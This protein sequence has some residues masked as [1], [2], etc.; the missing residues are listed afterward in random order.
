MSNGSEPTYLHYKL[1]LRSPAIIAAFS[2]DPNGAAT[3]VFIPGSAL[4]GV[5]AARLLASGISDQSDEFWRLILSGEV[6]YLHAYPELEGTRSMPTPVAWKRTRDTDD[7]VVDLACFSGDT[8]PPFDDDDDD[9]WPTEELVSCAEPF[10]S[11]LVSSGRWIV[12]TPIIGSRLH[13][14][15]DRVKGRPWKDQNE[16]PHGAIFA[17]EYLEADQVFCGA[18][19]IMPAAMPHLEQVKRLLEGSAI[20][21][22]RSRRA[23]YGGDAEIEFTG[24]HAHEYAYVP[25][26]LQHDLP[27]GTSFNAL[28]TSAYIGRHPT[29]G[30]L[31]PTTLGDELCRQLGGAATVERTRWAFTSVGGFNRKWRL[32]LPAAQAVA[33]G[34]GLVLTA[35][36]PIP[37]ARL[38]MLEHNGL[39]ERRNEG[40]GRLIFLEPTEQPY[41]LRIRREDEQARTS[42]SDEV[43][44][45]LEA[46][47]P[48]QR[49]QLRALEERIVLAAA[50]A[51]LDRVAT[52]ELAANAKN[53]PTTSLLG[54]LRTLFR[55]VVNEPTAQDALDKLARWCGDNEHHALKKPARDRL[56]RCQLKLDQQSL[57]LRAW[58]IQ[59]AQAAH[60]EEGWRALTNAAGNPDTL[61]GLATK[62]HLTQRAAAE[63]VL[64]RHT[65]LLRVYLIDALLAALAHANR[66]RA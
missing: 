20:V 29:T 6:R 49:Q 9:V 3:E 43:A 58:L 50:R 24:Q 39:G 55:P 66:G 33:A 28:L 25:R 64:Q 14:Q 42:S 16:Q 56:D 1:R 13:Q 5:V 51:E 18:I 32:E 59:I 53:R 27:A 44:R 30:Q 10:V 46:M 22:G 62:Y 63:A 34:S 40:F 48:E 52:L 17:Y 35:T 65:A 7:Q 38:R 12:A 4:R 11:A 41:M 26:H 54:R 47:A 19:Q 2:G 23:G 21:F 37:A 8:T 31:D 61:T 15:R 45:A 57:R 36:A 60:G